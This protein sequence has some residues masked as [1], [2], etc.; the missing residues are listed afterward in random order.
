MDPYRQGALEGDM[1]VDVEVDVDIHSC[2][3]CL[4]GVSR[5]VQV[6]S[7]NGIHAVMVLTL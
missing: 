1:A 4:K 3:G 2:L 7:N 6:L 5:S